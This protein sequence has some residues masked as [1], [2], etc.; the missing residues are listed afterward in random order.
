MRQAKQLML[1]MEEAKWVESE[2]KFVCP[3]CGF[4]VEGTTELPA[5]YDNE[6]EEFLPIA[7]TCVVCSTEFSGLVRTD[8]YRCEIELDEYPDTVV[9]AQPAREKFPDYD[10]YEQE[11]FDWLDKQEILSRPILYSL[12]ATIGDVEQ[13]A[14]KIT[15]EKESQTLARM[16]VVQSIAV[17]EVFL[18]DTL[19]LSVRNEPATQAKVIK[20]KMIGFG[21][22]SFQIKDAFGINGFTKVKLLEYL[23]NVSFHNLDKVSKFYKIGVGVDILATTSELD[24]F[25]GL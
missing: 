16:L 22:T 14:K 2:V 13:L 11:Y 1:E 17:L 9:K 6:S 24:L 25:I 10:D 20:S 8:W 7:V 15:L 12:L 19:I 3:E 23:K 5:I 4:E 18:S 21:G